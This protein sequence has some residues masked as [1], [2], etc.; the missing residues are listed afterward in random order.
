MYMYTCRVYV[1]IYLHVHVLVMYIV[2]HRPE[3][4]S[5]CLELT[6]KVM[7][8]T[9]EGMQSIWH[10]MYIQCISNVYMCMYTHMRTYIV[11]VYT[12]CIYRPDSSGMAGLRRTMKKKRV[13]QIPVQVSVNCFISCSSTCGM[14]SSIVYSGPVERM[15]TS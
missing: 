9:N 12:A 15:V 4:Y 7:D 8:R 2:H 3:C 11:H 1:Y 6:Q 14:W 10:N 13:V 5:E